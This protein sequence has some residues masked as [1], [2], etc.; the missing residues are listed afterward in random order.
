MAKEI[1]YYKGKH[2]QGSLSDEKADALVSLINEY[3]CVTSLKHCIKNVPKHMIME[4]KKYYEEYEAEYGS[5]DNIPPFKGLEDIPVGTLRDKQTIG[6]AFM[7]FAGS[8]L[9]GDSVG[10]GK[11]VQTA[12]LCN[13]KRGEAEQRNETFRYCFLTE[14]SNTGQIRDKMIQFTGEFVG[15][16]DSGERPVVE[17]FINSNRNGLNYSIVGS[18]SLLNSP[19]FITYC[20]KN[21]FD[22]IV[23]DE[24]SLLK[25]TS[26]ETYKNTKALF[27]V[28]KDKILLNATPLETDLR[29]FY[30]QLDL[31]DPDFMPTVS[32]FE[33]TFCKKAK[34]MMGFKT[35]GY[36]NDDMFK[37]LI[38]LRYLSRTRD[39]LD[40]K[41]EDNTWKTIY[42]PLSD[43]QKRLIKKTTMYQMVND[44]PTGVDRKVPFDLITTPKVAATLDILSGLDIGVDKVLIYCRFVD[45]QEKLKE[46]LEH[47]GFRSVILNGKTKV[48]DKNA[49]IN[50]FNNGV[51]DILITNVRKGLD[52]NE[53][54]V[55]IM[56]TIDP[57][58]QLMVQVE[59]RMT[60]EVDVIGKSVYL[61]V[62][63][64][65]EKKFVEEV[66]KMRVDASSKFVNTGKSMVVDAIQKGE[67][68][69]M[70]NNDC[71]NLPI[72]MKNN[73]DDEEEDD[74]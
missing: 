43:E 24:S 17:K 69:E 18:H 39:D 30:N 61:L 37:E 72:V 12:G 41:F 29:E 71:F 20:A 53:C 64:G 67:N 2:Y 14:K 1:K 65:K 19:E 63:M 26:S 34:G 13:V 62:S 5:L 45:C 70:F 47:H 6:V 66:L 9:L 59:G 11:T 25:N 15:L 42:I 36:K 10:L 22:L 51:H 38:S 50:G 27:K 40:A 73:E 8:A 31:L 74:E 57:N 21:P 7:Y 44:Y 48:K 68:K 23:V 56:Y 33:R 3:E 49:I 4:I 35:V 54:N 55:T 58:P 60:R 32:E 46:V 16:L 28:H 52:L